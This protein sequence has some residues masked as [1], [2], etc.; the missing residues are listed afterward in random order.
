MLANSG[1][2]VAFGPPALLLGM[3]DNPLLILSPLF[4]PWYLCA[5]GGYGGDSGWDLRD[6]VYRAESQRF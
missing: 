4:Y 6:L 3:E 2:P 5:L 1:V